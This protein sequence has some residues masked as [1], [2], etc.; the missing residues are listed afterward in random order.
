[1]L[2]FIAYKVTTNLRHL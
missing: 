2:N 1:M